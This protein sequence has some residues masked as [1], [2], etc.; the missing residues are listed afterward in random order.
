MVD[1]S[2]KKPFKIEPRIEA[3]VRPY[4]KQIFGKTEVVDHS[5]MVG[6]FTD[7]LQKIFAD[8]RPLRMLSKAD[9]RD[10]TF[11]IADSLKSHS[12]FRQNLRDLIETLKAV[13]ENM[14]C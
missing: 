1:G 9:T 2:N 6:K 7:G 14:D 10:A 12:R 13:E 3:F 5:K 8:L 11:Q 4:V